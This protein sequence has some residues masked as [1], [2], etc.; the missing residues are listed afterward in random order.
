MSLFDRKARL[1]QEMAVLRA[2]VAPAEAQRAAH[3]VAERVA[4]T[5]EFRAARC[6]ALYAPLADELDTRPL[7][8]LCRGQGKRV[9]LPRARSDG[10]LDFAAVEHWENLRPGRYGV[11]EPPDGVHG[12]KGPELV[13]APGV[14]FDGEGHRLGRG[15]GYYDRTFDVS[16][17]EESVLLGVAF[18]FQWVDHV[19]HDRR[20]RRMDAVV[21]ENALYRMGGGTVSP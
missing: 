14:A 7:F 8:E 20:D 1:R 19:P 17:A 6:I 16:G 15:K 5:P 4:S 21:T 9:L 18:E 11:L 2:A 12:G 3:A 10:R 13:C